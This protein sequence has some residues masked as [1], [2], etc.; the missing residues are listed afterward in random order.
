M[1]LQPYL[2]FD[3]R[4]EEALGFYASALGAKVTALMRFQDAPAHAS[5]PGCT[6]PPGDKVMHANLQIGDVQVMASDGAPPGEAAFK[7]FALTLTPFTDAEAE[8]LFQ[9]LSE[10]GQVQVPFGP[11]F[12]ASSFGMVADRFGVPWMVVLPLPE[13]P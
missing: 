2:F 5:G 12:F 9:A 10:G 11:T 1:Q 7:G 13:E 4:C 8:R 6:P 3:G